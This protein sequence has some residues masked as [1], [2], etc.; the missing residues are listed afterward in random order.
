MLITW[1]IIAINL[2]IFILII[3]PIQTKD[4]FQILITLIPIIINHYKTP[5]YCRTILCHL[6]GI[7]SLDY[8]AQIPMNKGWSKWRKLSIEKSSPNKLKKISK[9]SKI[10]KE[11]CYKKKRGDK[12]NSM[13][14]PIYKPSKSP[15]NKSLPIL[16]WEVQ[17]RKEKK[18]TV[19]STAG[20]FNKILATKQL[21]IILYNRRYKQIKPK[22]IQKYLKLWK[23]VGI[24]T[25]VRLTTS[26]HRNWIWTWTW[27]TKQITYKNKCWREVV[28]Y[29]SKRWKC[30]SYDKETIN[31]K[32]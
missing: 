32:E 26:K 6:Q 25:K 17:R 7:S 29:Q 31:R 2:L 21:K 23:E 13:N 24:I 14:R 27:K 5:P 22:T 9:G 8:M 28:Y 18:G 11:N 15:K 19:L 20:K 1:L 4:L 12:G 30:K 10:K 3:N 16:W